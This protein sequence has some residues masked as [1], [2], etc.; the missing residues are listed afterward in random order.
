MAPRGK[1]KTA[2]KA[3]PKKEPTEMK[4]PSRRRITF[5]VSAEPGS[6]VAVS[7]DFNN[8]DTT[9]HSMEDKKGDGN[10]TATILLASSRSSVPS[11]N[12]FMA[13]AET[14]NS[15]ST[16][17][18]VHPASTTPFVV[19]MMNFPLG[20]TVTVGTLANV[21]VVQTRMVPLLTAIVPDIPC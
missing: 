8:W 4:T 11:T 9:G 17:S 14:V 1:A 18:L 10:Y 3:A 2:R 12:G 19:S 15:P 20:P 7:G 21:D 5:S 13:S 16:A 6:R